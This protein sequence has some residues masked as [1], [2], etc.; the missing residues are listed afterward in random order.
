MILS[1]TVK[2][3]DSITIG[4]LVSVSSPLLCLLSP[5]VAV[6]SDLTPGDAWWPL[7]VIS[8]P[9]PGPQLQPRIVPRWSPGHRRQGR[10]C[11][12]CGPG[13]RGEPRDGPGPRDP[14]SE[15]AA[16]QWPLPPGAGSCW[17]WLQL[18]VT[19]RLSSSGPSSPCQPWPD[20]PANSRQCHI[21]D[22]PFL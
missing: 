4:P 21:G 22:I 14:R 1:K 3:L 9:L 6:T 15:C 11:S 7:S 13:R 17:R 18:P 2:T 10:D 12:W 19:S 20:I 5:R 16:H 8:Q